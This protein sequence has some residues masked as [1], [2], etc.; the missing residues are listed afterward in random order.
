M[1][2][3]VADAAAMLGAIA[4]PDAADPTAADAPVPD[5]LAT[6]D[7][8]AQPIRVGVPAAWLERRV[9]PETRALV[10]AASATLAEHGATVIDIDLPDPG[11]AVAALMAILMPEAA[12]WH[13]RWLRDRPDDYSSA[14]RERLELGAMTPAVRYLQGQQARR[15]LTEAFLTGMAEVDVIATPTAPTPATL[16]SSDLTVGEEA[17][18]EALAALVDFTAPFDLTGFPAISVPCG[19]TASGLPVGLQLVTRPWREDLLLAVAH[20]YERA[21]PWH[22]RLPQAIA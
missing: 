18:P 2:R 1:T 12:A 3:T 5:Y 22:R 9:A 15:T 20:A 21:A 13:L 8:A 6:L 7:E 17:D 11:E 19:F 10:E 16:L 14:V 4:G